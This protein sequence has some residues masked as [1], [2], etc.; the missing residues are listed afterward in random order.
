[1][2][3]KDERTLTQALGGGEALR[4]LKKAMKR[5]FKPEEDLLQKTL[6]QITSIQACKDAALTGEG[7]E[8]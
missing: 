3:E 4:G 6:S 7:I 5:I 1:M 8:A 2:A